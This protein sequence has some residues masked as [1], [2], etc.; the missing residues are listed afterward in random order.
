MEPLDELVAGL[1]PRQLALL[2]HLTAEELHELH[3]AIE[4]RMNKLAQVRVGYV[5]AENHPMVADIDHRGRMLQ[6]L[7]TAVQEA[8]ANL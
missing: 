7:D 3:L 8:R 1:P 2:P 5:H 4:E 6:S